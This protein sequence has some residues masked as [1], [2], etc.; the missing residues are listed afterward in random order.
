MAS[1]ALLFAATLAAAPPPPPSPA[2]RAPTET[3]FGITLEDPDRWLE[4][5]Q[6]PAARAWVEGQAAHTRALLDAIPARAEL[7]AD[8]ERLERAATSSVRDLVLMADG[9]ILLQRQPAGGDAAQLHLRDGWDGA[10][11][12]LLDPEDWKA[13][14]GQ[15]HA[16]NYMVP[17]PDGRHAVVGLSASGS[18]EATAY[19]IDLADGQPKGT[20]ISRVLFGVSWLPDASGFFY[21]RLNALGP[22]QPL[23][24]RQ[25]DS[26]AYLHRLGADPEKDIL[27]FGNRHDETLGIESPQLP[28]VVASRDSRFLVGIPYSV[29]NRLTLF[30]AP[31]ADL[32][33]GKLQ[34]RRVIGPED[35]VRDFAQHGDDLLLLTATSANRR[36]E[37]LALAKP[38]AAREV[39]VPAGLE[40]I[41]SLHASGDALYWVAMRESGV[42][43]RLFRLPWGGQAAREIVLP[44]LDTIIPYTVQDGARGIA[45]GGAGWARF[46]DIVRIDAEG[47][48]HPTTLQPAPAGVDADALEATIVQV[49]SHDGMLVP[50]SIV[51]RRGLIRDGRNPTLLNGYGAYGMSTEPFLVP[52]HFAFFDRG[53]VR[54]FCHVRG[55]GEKGEAWYR[56]GFQATKPNTWKDLIACAEYLVRE[57]YTAPARLAASGGS[58]GGIMIGNAMVERPDL[59][60]V[61]IPQVGALDMIGIAL[62]DPNGP[63]NWPEFGDPNT[64]E[65]FRSLLAMSA[66]HKVRDGTPFP[67]VM[68][69]HGYNDPRVAVWQSAKMAARLQ[70]ATTS[71]RPVLLNVDFEAGHGVGSAQRSVNAQRADLVAFL[72]WQ[73]GVEGYAPVFAEP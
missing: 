19:V 52:A 57:G 53:F 42:G 68:L 72:L 32:S 6:N 71:G 51:H 54:A 59:F 26:Q 24:E 34:W 14:T 13:K 23:A 55:G 40:P 15:P 11:R 36:I 58:A 65:G 12:L 66:Y 64:E 1:L 30:V 4:D 62:R 8:I 73:F 50:L 25:L 70:R 60:G 22:G 47:A 46:P 61:M 69:P 35:A 2:P 17:S 5:Q 9:R 37:R 28:F 7:L 27:V 45:I 44:A 33:S 18:E 41:D 21:N 16:I 3:R 67:A 38:D 39:V 48:V 43:A 29:D 20:P 31:L 63:V 56:A 49:P 10:E